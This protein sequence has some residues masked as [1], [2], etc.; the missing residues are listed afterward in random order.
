LILNETVTNAIK[1]AFPNE[2]QGVIRVEFAADAQ[3]G[4]A[5]LA[6]SDNGIGMGPPRPGGSGRDLKQA[7][8]AQLGGEMRHVA[9]PDGGARVEL[10][11]PIRLGF[12][13]TAAPAASAAVQLTSAAGQTA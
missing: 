6:V 2:R 11:F 3:T 13:N 4:L 10:H 12:T 8:A 5:M 7:L 9:P 1:H